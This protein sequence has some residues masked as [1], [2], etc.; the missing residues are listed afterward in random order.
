MDHAWRGNALTRAE[1]FTFEEECAVTG[2]TC[3]VQQ[4]QAGDTAAEDDEVL[5]HQTGPISKAN[6][7]VAQYT[8]PQC[9]IHG[10]IPRLPAAGASVPLRH[11]RFSP[12]AGCTPFLVISL[13]P[14]FCHVC[15]CAPRTALVG[16][17]VSV[18]TLLRA[19]KA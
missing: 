19:P 12:C 14:C 2:F 16:V 11:S 8:L 18:S 7:M 5:V 10:T 13:C 6:F 17:S 15:G 3:A 9:G 4:P 1:R